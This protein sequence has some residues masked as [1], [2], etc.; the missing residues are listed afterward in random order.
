MTT[1]QEA[2]RWAEERGRCEGINP[3]AGHRRR[4]KPGV[5]V[6]GY[7]PW[8]SEDLAKLFAP[9]PTRQDVMEI[10][11]VGLFT[12]LR[13]DEIASLTY[14]QI[15]KAEGVPFIQVADAKTP[16][17]RRQVPIHANLSWLSEREGPASARVWLGFNP[18]GPG[19]KAGADAGR[20]FSRFKAAKGFKDRRLTFHSFRKNVTQIFERAGIPENEAAQILGH[21]RGF[22][23]S[24]YS[25]HGITLAR[26]K[27][28]VQLIDYPGLS[29]PSPTEDHMSSDGSCNSR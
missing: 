21:E 11:L 10:M 29:F 17:G 12:G 6:Q 22:T 13:L 8:E 28:I 2:W 9:P 5:N 19:K 3:F 26:K 4:L 20:E 24:R 23:Y 14:G 1:L 27:E 16:A 18:E 15:K 25:P 7:L